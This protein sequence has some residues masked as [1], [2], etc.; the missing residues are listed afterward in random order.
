MM[1][2][3]ASRLF[4]AIMQTVLSDREHYQISLEALGQNDFERA[5]EHLRVLVGNLPEEGALWFN[6]GSALLGLGRKLEA[7]EA[8]QKAASLE[9]SMA[10]AF[11][12]CGVILA[13]MNPHLAM[14]CYFDCLNICEHADALYNLAVLLIRLHEFEKAKPFLLRAKDCGERLDHIEYLLSAI[15]GS[16]SQ[17]DAPTAFVRDLFD[18]YAAKFDEHIN[19]LGYQTPILIAHKLRERFG[20]QEPLILDLGCGTGLVGEELRLG[21]ITGVDLS[22]KMLAKAQLKGVYHKLVCEDMLD[23]LKA[24]TQNFDAIVAADVFVYVGELARIFDACFRRLKHKGVFVFSIE[25]SE[26]SPYELHEGA[27][28]S[29]YLDYVKNQLRMSGFNAINTQESILRYQS[30]SE[31]KGA[32]IMAEKR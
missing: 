6:L 16:V 2:S 22:S 7:L 26:Q 18:E 11:F 29:H 9:P 12:N 30:G 13:D 20:A 23:F 1:L 25:L 19:T 24:S 27:R 21:Q 31:V 28:Y 17:Q 5:L 4:R 8:Y 3:K 14:D 32:L 15:S 10:D